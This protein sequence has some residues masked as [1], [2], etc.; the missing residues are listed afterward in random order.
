VGAIRSPS[1][2]VWPRWYAAACHTNTAVHASVP[3]HPPKARSLMQPTVSS[4]AGLKQATDVVPGPSRALCSPSGHPCRCNPP[5]LGQHVD[6]DGDVAAGHHARHCSTTTQ[7]PRW[8]QHSDQHETKHRE[9]Q[10]THGKCTQALTSL[11]DTPQ[12]PPPPPNV[13]RC[14]PMLSTHPPA[15]RCMPESAGR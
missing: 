6:L 1:C 10:N 7:T 15:P 2:Y 9:L 5:H 3:A 11:P 14:T 4:R 12:S 13:N 8:H